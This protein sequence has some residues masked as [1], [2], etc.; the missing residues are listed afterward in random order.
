MIRLFF[1]RLYDSP[2]L[3]YKLYVCKQLTHPPRFHF[4][5]LRRNNDFVKTAHFQRFPLL[6]ILLQCFTF[7][8]YLYA[9][10]RTMVRS[11]N[12]ECASVNFPLQNITISEVLVLGAIRLAKWCLRS[13]QK[14]HKVLRVQNPISNQGLSLSSLPR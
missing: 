7:H 1:C 10:L 6:I 3:C 8:Y 12:E 4:C 5:F 9:G 14:E 11:S 13:P 2:N